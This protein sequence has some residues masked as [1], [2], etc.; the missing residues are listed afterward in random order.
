MIRNYSIMAVTLEYTTLSDF[1]DVMTETEQAEATDDSYAQGGTIN[2]SGPTRDDQMTKRFLKR[3]ES[4]ADTYVG[5][6]YTIPLTNPS[7]MF[8]YTVMVIARY[9]LDD[10]GDGDVSEHVMESYNMAIG[11]LEDI[12]DEVAGIEGSEEEIEDYY[13]EREGG[14]FGGS[15]G[16]D[17]LPFNDKSTSF[18]GDPY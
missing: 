15:T 3:A 11:W 10:R 5:T 17:E 16:D 8:K 14:T 18:T 12:R 13:G 9:L 1:S 6:R 4:I 2:G 7:P